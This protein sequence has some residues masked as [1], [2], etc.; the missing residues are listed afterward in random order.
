LMKRYQY[1]SNNTL[2]AVIDE[3]GAQFA[4]WEYNS[5]A[6]AIKSFRG[7]DQETVEILSSTAPA[8]FTYDQKRN[9]KVVN[10][11]GK[12]TTY[13]FENRGGKWK[14][15]RVEGHAKGSCLAANQNYTYDENG[16]Q[17]TV[18]D[19]E[20]N[21]TDYDY[22][23]Y[24]IL[25]KVTEAR[26]TSQERVTEYTWNALLNKP[27]TIK[28][29]NLKHQF[30]YNARGLLSNH[31]TTELS[32]EGRS[33]ATSY[34]YT[35][36]TNGL[37]KT[38]VIDGPRVDVSDITTIE[39]SSRGYVSKITNAL[40]HTTL[41]SN[42]NIFGQPALITR[43][44][45]SINRYSY[46]P[47]GWLLKS[48]LD[49]YGDKRTTI[50]SYD[51]AGQLIKLTKPDASIFKFSY[52]SAHRLASVTNT[53][54]ESKV[55]T[56]DA[57]SNL[58]Q[59]SIKHWVRKMEICGGGGGVIPR[60]MDSIRGVPDLCEVAKFETVKAEKK[61]YDAL[62]RLTSIIQG[63]GEDSTQSGDTHS[64]HNNQIVSRLTYD[65]NNQPSTVSDGK[66]LVTEKYYDALGRVYKERD[67][68]GKITQ[69][70]YGFNDRIIKVKDPRGL[71]THYTYNGFG[72][73]IKLESPDTGVTHFGYDSAG[74]LISK[75]DANGIISSFTYDAINRI[76]NEV[77]GNISRSHS[78]DSNRK[79]YLYRK[80][81]EAG[82]HTFTF[83]AH[84]ELVKRIES[85]SGLTLTTEWKYNK[86]GKVSEIIHPNGMKVFN[87]FDSQG[88]LKQV[89]SNG[90]TVVKN[91]Q[92]KP[93]GP[94][95]YLQFG[96]NL[97]RFYNRDN[98]YR[99]KR[100]MSGSIINLAYTYDNNSNITQ[101]DDSYIPAATRYKA[102][103]Y[104]KID[105][106][107]S[108]NDYGEYHNY[109]YD[110]NSNRLMKGNTSYTIS[111]TSNRLLDYKTP[112][113]TSFSYDNNGNITRSGYSY[114]FYNDANRLSKYTKGAMSAE[115]TYNSLGQRVVKSVKG[116]K[117][118]FSYDI[119][120]KLLYERNG[121]T[122]KSYIYR[123]KE[124]VG[125]TI[126]N[127]V[128]LV[129]ADHQSRPQI[130]TDMNNNVKWEATNK[131][132]DRQVRLNLIG[133]LNIG[134]PG[135]YYDAEK[136]SWY[137]YFRDYDPRIG[138]YLQS[139]P[140]GLNG[141]INT[142]SYVQS[143]PVNYADPL[144]L[145]KCMCPHNPG[146]NETKKSTPKDVVGRNTIRPISAEQ[147][148]RLN[149]EATT[150]AQLN[151][152]YA[153]GIGDV[154]LGAYLLSAPLSG[155]ASLAIGGV[156]T[157]G[158]VVV[159]SKISVENYL[160]G[161]SYANQTH[162]H[163]AHSYTKQLSWDRKG[164]FLGAKLISG[165]CWNN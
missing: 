110:A 37:I 25:N 143:N 156:Y 70:W 87:H 75:T 144:G 108:T 84:G 5:G 118:W 28:K 105:R 41:F 62:S 154:A 134:F 111:G 85:L 33:R 123:N 53:D 67:R 68:N 91:I 120:G 150:Q 71:D 65:K 1:G 29:E 56:Y 8:G 107:S 78:Y 153:A 44:D 30:D 69:Y 64:S 49:I 16:F 63:I 102:Y 86:A 141:G 148:K 9:V 80:T 157:L 161:Y 145:E 130:V 27:L 162:T 6:K 135:Q 58:T 112:Q 10:A 99:I 126:N 95:D 83:N 20:G 31:V 149:L 103:T 113:V 22:D 125:L 21:V 79:G 74:N 132:F 51:K 77:I 18:S 82:T 104:D 57:A 94:V 114:F 61:T 98:R 59:E 90:T 46:H 2:T 92:Y 121:S 140:I 152:A 131:A 19:W 35:Y 43:P 45:G 164:N 81:D 40:G 163:G 72:D 47:R 147:A 129:H 159:G 155:G 142:Y 88:R 165:G 109:N 160:E 52:D 139:D 66:G 50:Y 106:L 158:S 137:N 4:G 133:D 38:K 14:V 73:L 97:A 138:R 42:H 119:D 15:N 48:E 55:Y 151:F 17:D 12:Q 122:H 100:I 60:S 101:I 89:A 26:S 96:N 36:H 146:K 34:D 115:Y 23:K 11:L 136:D 117:T 24:G 93:F 3:N 76:K 124:L 127:V 54:N 39:Y 32:G 116:N 128:Y 7:I 13:H